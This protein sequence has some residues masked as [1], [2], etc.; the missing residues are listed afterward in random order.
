MLLCNL[1]VAAHQ[2]TDFV[3]VLELFD[4]HF[5]LSFPLRLLSPLVQVFDR[6]V[7]DVRVCA[8]ASAVHGVCFLPQKNSMISCMWATSRTG[9]RATMSHSSGS[10]MRTIST[11]RV[12]WLQSRYTRSVRAL[13]TMFH[14]YPYWSS[15][16]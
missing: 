2:I 9:I 14:W 15:H 3:V 7:H 16:T 12:S 4:L 1:L 13:V 6:G 10:L 11:S 5:V 8:L